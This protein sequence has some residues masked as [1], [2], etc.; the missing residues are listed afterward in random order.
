M[1]TLLAAACQQ[2]ASSVAGEVRA[3]LPERGART[4]LAVQDGAAPAVA[5]DLTRGHWL[6]LAVRQEGVDVTVRVID[7]DGA[8]ILTVDSPTGRLGREPVAFLTEREGVHHLHLDASRSGQVVVEVLESRPATAEDTAR[9]AATH[10]L[11]RGIFHWIEDEARPA[12]T[13]LRRALEGFQAVGGDRAE[14]DA[15]RWL[16]AAVAA[17][18]RLGEA[19]TLLLHAAEEFAEQGDAHEEAKVR[20]ELG[21]LWRRLGEPGEAERELLRAREL[22]AAAGNDADLALVLNHL[23]L[24]WGDLGRLGEA[25]AAFEESLHLREQIGDACGVSS[26][27]RSLGALYVLI[28]RDREALDFLESAHAKAESCAVDTRISAL[29]ELGWAHHLAGDGDT[30]LAH[31]DAA[32][33]LAREDSRER[34]LMAALDRR[35]TVLAS[36][37]RFDAA[38]TSY[39]QALRQADGSGDRRSRGDVLANL[40]RLAR[41]AGDAAGAVRDLRRAL[42]LLAEADDAEAEAFTRLEL[43]RALRTL[44]QSVA[45]EKELERALTRVETVRA[46]L[47]SN[48]SR[49]FFLAHRREIYDELID[50]LMERAAAA[51][52]ARHHLRALEVSERARARSLL[53]SIAQGGGKAAEGSAATHRTLMTGIERLDEERRRLREDGAPLEQIQSL[54]RRLRRMALVAERLAAPPSYPVERLLTASELPS[55]LDSETDLLVF[56]LGATASYAWLVDA[57][58]RVEWFRLPPAARLEGLARRTAG[59]LSSRRHEAVPRSGAAAALARDLLGPIAPHLG[60]RRLAI[61]LD[62]ALHLVPLQALP[63]PGAA[64]DDL[65][66]DRVEVVVVP[67]PSALAEQRARPSAA[68]TGDVF[69]VADPVFTPDDHRVSDGHRVAAASLPA[70]L[71]RSIE[72]LDLD[73]LPRLRATRQE[74]QAILAAAS[75]RPTELLLDFAADR[76]NFLA[77][78]VRQ[79]RTAHFATHA[80]LHPTHPQLSGVILSLVGPDGRPRD[81]FLRAWQVAAMELPAELVV[82]SACST[83]LGREVRAEGLIGLPQAFFRAGARRVVVSHWPV[84]DRATA[85]LMGTFY[86]ALLRDGLPPGTALARAQRKLRSDPRW[87][88]PYYW[89]GF[90][91]Q[92]DWRPLGGQQS[93]P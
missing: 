72:A 30:A 3:L 43:A 21:E 55:V 76:G 27:E 60:T 82:L 11:V 33:D 46:G 80:I 14:S 88:A 59:E 5:L 2:P 39:R 41:L 37:S 20:T 25:E 81:G 62:G 71:E 89:A 58:G 15:R 48:T 26:T 73:R 28:G 9:F 70:D 50:L 13:E 75:P 51:P 90:S 93:R 8:E 92:G 87:E 74:A 1:V 4:V 29:V 16:A 45:A 6:R 47:P 31:L 49:S 85:K 22:F 23:G 64:G 44:D 66:L 57:D 53:D 86:E 19:V 83:G 56:S 54:D 77:G 35:G 40:G 67:S 18:G 38:R 61:V 36:L 7:A 63:L 78:D 65:L 79:Y 69:V 68:H 17:D 52:A 12:E 91:L 42:P 24:L 84:Q 32:V 10:A 34:P